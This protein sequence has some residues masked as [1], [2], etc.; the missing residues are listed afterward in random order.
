MDAWTWQRFESA[1]ICYLAAVL[2]AIA[3]TKEQFW[4]RKGHTVTL[5]NVLVGVSPSNHQSLKKVFTPQDSFDALDI[6]KDKEQCIRRANA[7]SKVH[8]VDTKDLD[9]MHQA[10]DGTPII[11]A[12]VN[13]K[14]RDEG[15]WL[16]PLLQVQP[17]QQ[18]MKLR[19][20]SS[21]TSI[22]NWSQM[23]R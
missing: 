23:H 14:L 13:L 2:H 5:S 4:T 22:A 10:L 21:S 11:D 8:G 12:Y 15:T 6:I 9:H 17:L 7:R 1:H 18:W 20:S 3:E 16:Q 19:L